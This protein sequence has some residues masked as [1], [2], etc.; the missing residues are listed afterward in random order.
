MPAKAEPPS[1]AELK[2]TLGSADDLW[3]AIVGVVEERAAP[4]EFAWRPSKSAFGRACLLQ[5]K[6]RTLLYLTPEEGQIRIAIVLGDRA[7]RL[8]MASSLPGPIKTMFAEATPYSEGRGIR[9]S[10]S[11]LGDLPAI[12]TLVAIKTTPPPPKG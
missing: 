1:P 6:K 7:Y 4:L 5:H 2:K 3:T 11:K 12:R 8:A 9:Y 10:V